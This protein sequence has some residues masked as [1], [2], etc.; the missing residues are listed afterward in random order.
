M[1]ILVALFLTLVGCTAAQIQANHVFL[2][3]LGADANTVLVTGCAN[4]PATEMDISL[5]SAVTP[6]DP[7]VKS[8]VAVDET[9]ANIICAKLAAD[10]AAKAAQTVAP[11]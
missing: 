2:T 1:M 5:I 10:Q 6:P 11:K 3:N 4:L 9:V 8:A 7:T